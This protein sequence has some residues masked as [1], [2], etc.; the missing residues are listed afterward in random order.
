MAWGPTRLLCPW[1]FPGKTAGVGCH[2]L[3]Q[4]S[5]PRDQT[6]VSHTAGRLFTYWATREDS[7][8]HELRG[9]PSP[10]AHCHE[11]GGLGEK[12]GDS[13]RAGMEVLIGWH[14]SW[15][16][17]QEG[18]VGTMEE[19]AGLLRVLFQDEEQMWVDGEWGARLSP[20]GGYKISSS[21]FRLCSW[22]VKNGGQVGLMVS[23]TFPWVPEREREC[24]E[25]RIRVPPL[26]HPSLAVLLCGTGETFLTTSVSFWGQT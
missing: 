4:G 12:M 11:G 13:E 3:L 7:R 20:W 8:T 16:R 6:R 24:I 1:D 15:D 26:D 25:H 22:P 19:G 23:G 14:C 2:S 10:C 21:G 17:G 18:A 9:E 5:Q